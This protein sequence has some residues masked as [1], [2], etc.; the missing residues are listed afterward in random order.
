VTGATPGS[1]RPRHR[2]QG[3]QL[4]GHTHLAAATEHPAHHPGTV[5]P[6][7]QPAPTRQSWRTSAGLRSR[8][9][10][11]AQRRRTVLQP[12]QAV[13]RHRHP[14]RQDRRVLPSS[15]HPRITADVGVTFDD[16][17]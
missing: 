7:P 2:R 17:S 10:Q 9:L 8:G 16:D 11:A 15:R 12:P 3:L 14:L 1:A 5:R 6:G 4:Q 13:A